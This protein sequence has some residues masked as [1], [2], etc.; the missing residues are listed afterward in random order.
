VEALAERLEDRR[1]AQR[2][3]LRLLHHVFRHRRERP[4][5]VG[6]GD[7]VGH[8]RGRVVRRET[9]R[10]ERGL[11]GARVAAAA[12][13][14]LAGREVSAIEL[15]LQREGLPLGRRQRRGAG[16]QDRS[17]KQGNERSHHWNRTSGRTFQD[18][19]Q[20]IRRVSRHQRSKTAAPSARRWVAGD[21][22]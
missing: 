4:G 15:H 22:T 21:H 8:G 7:R 2:G 11:R 6:I 1:V 3:Q 5:G 12:A 18:R 13:V 10:R 9:G 17:E 16:Q 19:C 14:D 20:L